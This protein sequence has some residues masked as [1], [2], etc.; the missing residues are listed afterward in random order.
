M[1]M[2]QAQDLPLQGWRRRTSVGATL[3]VA[4]SMLPVSRT[5]CMGTYQSPNQTSRKTAVDTPS[6]R[7]S[8]LALIRVH[9]PD[10]AAFGSGKCTL[11]QIYARVDIG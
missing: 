3:V 7:F 9:L 10:C 4:R 11:S 6:F 2:G 5:Q 1:P 8:L